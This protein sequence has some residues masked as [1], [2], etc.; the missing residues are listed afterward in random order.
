MCDYTT[1]LPD[2]CGTVW[3]LG[4]IFFCSSYLYPDLTPVKLNWQNQLKKWILGEGDDCV[5]VRMKH[6]FSNKISLRIYCRDKASKIN[7][8]SWS[9]AGAQLRL[10]QWELKY[11]FGQMD[12][13][14]I[15][16]FSS[17]WNWVFLFKANLLVE[18]LKNIE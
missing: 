13:S 15:W 11:K 10:R 9:W 7:K 17:V 12:I 16:S 1:E 2:I 8:T 4:L 14:L 18:F 3:K 5:C 6:T